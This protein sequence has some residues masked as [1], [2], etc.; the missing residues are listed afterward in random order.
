MLRERLRLKGEWAGDGERDSKE[1]GYL[2]RLREFS[3]SL[4]GG[5]KGGGG[6]RPDGDGGWQWV[7]ELARG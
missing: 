6:G 3:G 1:G 2:D 4:F 7:K 5:V